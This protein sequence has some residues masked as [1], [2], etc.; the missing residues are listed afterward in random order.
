[1]VASHDHVQRGVYGGQKKGPLMVNSSYVA[2]GL[3]VLCWSF[4]LA[5]VPSQVK[6]PAI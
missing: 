2:L 6:A 5:T 1:M 3:W 4:Y